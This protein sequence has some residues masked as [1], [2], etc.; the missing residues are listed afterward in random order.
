MNLGKKL[1]K[2]F[3]RKPLK[4]GLLIKR[5]LLTLLSITETRVWQQVLKRNPFLFLYSH[6]L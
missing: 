1:N 2:V 4:A 3:K 6:N 5:T